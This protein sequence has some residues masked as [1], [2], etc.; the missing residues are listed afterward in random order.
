MRFIFRIKAHINYCMYEKKKP[1]PFLSRS[2]RRRRRSSLLLRRLASLATVGSG[3][4]FFLL[5]LADLHFGL[6]TLKVWVAI[7]LQRDVLCG[8]LVRSLFALAGLE[9]RRSE[10]AIGFGEVVVG[11]LVV[12]RHR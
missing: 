9:N 1:S 2:K 11:L 3:S 7:W 8:Y 12:V 4:N 5:S 10:V 6:A